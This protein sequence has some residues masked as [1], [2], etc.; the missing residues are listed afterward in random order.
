VRIDVAYDGTAFHGW[1]TQPGLR[2]V[3]GVLEEGLALVL[4]EAVRIVGA[5]R[6]DAGCHA[7]GQVASFVTDGRL[8]VSALVATLRRQL[9]QD[10]AV[11]RAA[12]APTD[13]D[14]RRSAQARRY[15]YRLL[16]RSDVLTQRIAWFPRRPLDA[17]A[18][19]TAMRPLAGV[20]DCA[21]FAARGGSTTRAECRIHRA[22]WRRWEGGLQLDIVADHFLY[23]MVR[24]V[25]GTALVAMRQ[26]D[27]AAAMEA[28]VSSRDR[29]KAGPTA[30][31]QGL[32]LEEV[33]YPTGAAS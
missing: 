31:P 32:C 16:D 22:A 5:G 4:G 27:P 15:A 28:V 13:F 9:P 10:V 11:T 23:H 20:R 6:T 3:Q 2:T 33:F 24:N 19:E 1:Q 8:P 7:R 26:P 12:E 29:S 30:P 18:L 25:V 14:A 17:E 21:A